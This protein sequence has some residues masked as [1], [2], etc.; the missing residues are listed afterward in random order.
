MQTVPSLQL[1]KIYYIFTVIF[2]YSELLLLTCICV[3]IIHHVAQRYR[4]ASAVPGGPVSSIKLK[5]LLI[6]C[7]IIFLA[8]LCVRIFLSDH[9]FFHDN[10]HGFQ[11]VCKMKHLLQYYDSR[12]MYGA[13]GFSFYAIFLHIFPWDEKTLFAVNII[14]GSLCCCAIYFLVL[15]TM[16][17]KNTALL[18]AL[19]LSTLPAHVRISTSEIMTI[20][21]SLFGMAGLI[22][23]ALAVRNIDSRAFNIKDFIFAAKQRLR[24]HSTGQQRSPGDASGPPEKQAAA[25]TSPSGYLLGGLFLIASAT[26][27]SISVQFLETMNLF[28]PLMIVFL[29]IIPDLAFRARVRIILSWLLLFVPLTI[30]HAVFMVFYSFRVI[31]DINMGPLLTNYTNIIPCFFSR[32]NLLFDPGIT[33]VYYA[34]ACLAGTG[35]AVFNIRK[36]KLIFFVFASL[37]FAAVSFM[38]TLT[39]ADRIMFHAHYQPYI[40]ALAAAGFMFLIRRLQ[41]YLRHR[42]VTYACCGI[43][44]VLL[45]SPPIY[46]YEFL[47]F[48]NNTQ[49]TSKFIDK[50]IRDI[51]KESVIVTLM[52][53]DLRD[54]EAQTIFPT[55]K[56]GLE[57]GRNLQPLRWLLDQQQLEPGT[58]VVY[59]ESPLCYTYDIIS[60]IQE[61]DIHIIF[62]YRYMN[63]LAET[64]NGTQEHKERALCKEVRT[65]FHLIPIAEEEFESA[66]DT[67]TPVFQKRIKT[68]F[69]KVGE[70]D[71]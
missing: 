29:L 59:F 52:Q 28:A 58:E 46:S 50:H 65:R 48:R 25:S 53:E 24:K 32:V 56:K 31:I 70:H 42:F 38:K 62:T 37:L 6:E 67:L 61:K 9:N 11:Y 35:I 54:E 43:L 23:A 1:D 18:A 68:G 71:S 39:T 19:I 4:N 55:C 57:C 44:F 16:H 2:F 64:L 63:E 60:Y 30:P 14:L 45:V 66:T 34:A 3:V 21:G 26:A 27:T 10:A 51:P 36:S 20:G 69:Y 13:G 41:G 8:A 15:F 5:P 47:H 22:F 7:G 49:R 17:E 33:P 40:A 12:S